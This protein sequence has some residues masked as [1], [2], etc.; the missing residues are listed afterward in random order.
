M[1]TVDREGDHKGYIAPCDI[2][3]FVLQL[4][5]R[6][7]NDYKIQ[8][9]CKEFHILQIPSLMIQI[10]LSNALSVFV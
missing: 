10:K 4:S 5:K 8:L 9:Y 7:L 3:Q 6:F 1:I 2:N